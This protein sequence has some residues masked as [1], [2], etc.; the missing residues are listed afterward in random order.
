MVAQDLRV[1]GNRSREGGDASLG[2]MQSSFHLE[3]MAQWFLLPRVSA[4]VD[5]VPTPDPRLPELTVVIEFETQLTQ[6]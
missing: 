1:L 2:R 3:I 5:R 4:Q 6:N